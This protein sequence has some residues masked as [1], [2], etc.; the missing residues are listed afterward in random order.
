MGETEMALGIDPAVVLGEIKTA[1]EILQSEPGADRVPLQSIELSLLTIATKNAEGKPAFKLPII[2]WSIGGGARITDEVAH[3][4]KITLV[5]P[6][7]STAPPAPVE[8]RPNELVLALRLIRDTAIA[9]EKEPNG[10]A[11]K[12]GSA[13]IKFGVTR[14]GSI[15]LAIVEVGASR[16][17][18]HSMTV[19]VGSGF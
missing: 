1:L 16:E 7:P 19:T 15:A 6:R 14:E 18:T 12:D 9:A 8:V 13:E 11:L 5:P 17:E 2:G 10:L 3:H 4:V